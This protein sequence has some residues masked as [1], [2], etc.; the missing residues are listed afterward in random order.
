MRK[1]NKKIVTILVTASFVLV[2]VGLNSAH[3]VTP[4]ELGLGAA[5]SY[6]V[7]GKAGV[8]TTGVTH[9]WGDAGADS[10]VGLISSQVGGSIYTGS[11]VAGVE[12]DARSTYDSLMSA[13]QGTPAGAVTG[14][15]LSG[16]HTTANSNPIVPGVYTIGSTTM[17]GAVELSGAGVYIFRSDA[18]A[19]IAATSAAHMTLTNGA[20]ASNVFWV[21]PASMTI[22]TGAHIE[23]TII[24]HEGLI[25]LATG[26]SLVGRAIS[27][28]SQVTLDANQITEPICSSPPTTGT[29]HVIKTLNNLHGG[30]L[31]KENFSFS[32][33]GGGSVAFESN[34]TND[35]TVAAGTYSVT[36]SAV[37]GY[38]T[39]YNNCT[40][41]VIAAG[42]SATCTITN[43][44]IAAHLIVIKHVV[45]DSGGSALASAF[46][47]TIT[48]VT[49]ATPTAVGVEYPG[50]DNILTSVGA[51]SVDEGEHIGYDKTLST[52]C[53][54]TITLGQTKTC[55]ITN[56]DI[57]PKLH[58]RKII[59]GG[60]ATVADFLL[61]ANG[62]GANDISGTSPV[63][64]VAGLLADTFALSETNLGRYTSSA[65]VCVGGT[66][67]G[68]NITLNINEEATC[69]I[70]NT[71]IQPV[72]RGGS[73]ITYGCKDPTATNYNAFS[74]S[75][76]A[77][78]LYTNIPVV[79]PPV[80]TPLLPKT[81]F[82]PRESNTWYEFLLNNI[83]NLFR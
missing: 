65:W 13:L 35:L 16:T 33:N 12:T 8:T 17:N 43:N 47:T 79:T 67:V 52:D 22:G 76:P 42:G 81:G 55:T 74:A 11:G 46:L 69:T 38:E 10:S 77:L 50:V 18:S 37:V 3:A 23:G 45:N 49:T 5:D 48:S 31:N 68:S 72:N 7:F 64:S 78:C 41:L 25:S 14:L 21:I 19:T 2:F 30:T 4:P 83:L 56:N 80:V 58:L 39:S 53:S 1:Y 63:D 75:N 44:D 60:T 36:E 59:N 20:C 27:L 32:V 62:T 61:T 40:D 82:P 34:G 70:T 24:A 73:S 57:D 71:Y 26:A 6:S 15:N 54:G 28:I 51:Y 9:V 29:L 66:Q